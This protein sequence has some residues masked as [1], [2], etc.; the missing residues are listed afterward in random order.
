MEVSPGIWRPGRR[1]YRKPSGPAKA[2]PEPDLNCLAGRARL[3]FFFFLKSKDEGWWQG[4][5]CPGSKKEKG[6]ALSKDVSHRK[7]REE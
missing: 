7:G 3:F 6:K 5:S 1:N 4:H 2:E